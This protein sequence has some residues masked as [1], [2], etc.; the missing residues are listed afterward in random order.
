M[1]R[2]EMKRIRILVAD[3]HTIVREGLRALFTR[4]P[5]FSVVG[6]AADGAEAVQQVRER[7]PD[8]VVIDIS[9]PGVNGI[10]AVRQ[11]KR[12]RSSTR[13][14]V[15]TIHDSEEY[16]HEMVGAGAD[17]YVVKDAEKQELLAAVRAVYAGERFFSAGISK[18]IVENFIRSSPGSPSAAQESGGTLTPREIEVLRYIAR[19]LTNAEIAQT[20]F[21]SV[22]TIGT[23]RANLMQKLNIHNAASLVR[24]ALEHGI[25]PAETVT[26]SVPS[27][28]AVPGGGAE[29]PHGRK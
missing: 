1:R 28:R 11:I 7:K 27:I 17:G 18:L 6:E 3:D 24:Y 22:R 9:M 15:L 16:V 2:K 12:I 14:L 20:M 8:V 10:V 29:A 26:A 5:E 19:G 13:V 21:L 23:H 25:V 4:F